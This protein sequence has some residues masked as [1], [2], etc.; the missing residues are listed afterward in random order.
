MRFVFVICRCVCTYVCACMC[1]YMCMCMCIHIYI[2]CVMHLS[3]YIIYMRI[4]LHPL[5]VLCNGPFCEWYRR[6]LDETD[7]QSIHCL[8]GRPV[9]SKSKAIAIK[10]SYLLANANLPVSRAAVCR[11]MHVPLFS[12]MYSWTDVHVRKHL[13][14]V[15][16]WGPCVPLL[17]SIRTNCWCWFV[18]WMNRRAPW[19]WFPYEPVPYSPKLGPYITHAPWCVCNKT[20]IQRTVWCASS[21]WIPLVVCAE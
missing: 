18:K 6:G 21:V 13:C 5:A 9:S 7:M 15:V 20:A 3:L 17:W 4:M 12:C 16:C 19:R 10:Y 2:L 8:R 11:C 1:A 14:L